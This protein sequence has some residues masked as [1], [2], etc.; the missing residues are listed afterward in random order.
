MIYWFDSSQGG[1]IKEA[2]EDY[3]YDFIDSYG[4]EPLLSAEEELSLIERIR[5][6]EAAQEALDAPTSKLSESERKEHQF[7]ARRGKKAQE[8]FIKANIRLSMHV[9]RRYMGRGL[10]FGDLVQEG[11]FGITHA[12]RK[13]E[14]AR[15]NR[16]S[17]YATPWIRQYI[18]RAV[19]NTGSTIRVPE[20]RVNEIHKVIK[21][22]NALL[23]QLGREATLDEISG[24]TGKPV[25]TLESLLQYG[26][27]PISLQAPVGE[28]TDELGDILVD[29]QFDGPEKEYE[30]VHLSQ[31]LRS[32]LE[33]LTEREQ[34]LMGLKYGLSEQG[35]PLSLAAAAEQ[36][37][38]SRE[39]ARQIERTALAKLRH[40]KNQ[41]LH[42]FLSP[43]D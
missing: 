16:F 29:Q 8:R 31:Q 26:Q 37:N 3:T 13:F 36:M 41:H 32:V 30:Q 9:A 6:G 18:S 1:I 2:V 17:T 34:L 7:C 25:S 39:R 38:I 23:E 33:G 35:E 42:A 4:N 5:A 24:A 10:P 11:I 12:I 43:A 20:H 15:G 27:Q 19:I 22:R 40:P 28:E 21:T 14:P